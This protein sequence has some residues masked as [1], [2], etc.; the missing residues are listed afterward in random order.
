MRWFLVFLLVGCAQP[1][2][3]QR[4][5][6]KPPRDITGLSPLPEAE[7]NRI[8]EMGEENEE[9]KRK[10]SPTPTPWR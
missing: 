10:L 2:H 3:T 8:S 6:R 7:A 4:H 1:A 5:H 9:L